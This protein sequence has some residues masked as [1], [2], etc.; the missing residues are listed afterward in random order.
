MLEPD[1]TDTPAPAND[2]DEGAG[3]IGSPIHGLRWLDAVPVAWRPIL[4]D[5]VESATLSGMA[6]E[7][8]DCVRSAV[9]QADKAADLSAEAAKVASDPA[10]KELLEHCRR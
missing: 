7:G 4:R 9:H 8:L 6:I 3:P 2:D 1:S 10:L 5:A